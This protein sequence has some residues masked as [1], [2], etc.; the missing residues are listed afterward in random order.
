MV[1]PRHFIIRIDKVEPAG[2]QVVVV[3]GVVFP[4]N[5]HPP[6]LGEVHPDLSVSLFHGID[7]SDIPMEVP[8]GISDIGLTEPEVPPIPNLLAIAVEQGLGILE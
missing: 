8:S 6:V 3:V 1:E 5:P 7:P 2:F 4:G